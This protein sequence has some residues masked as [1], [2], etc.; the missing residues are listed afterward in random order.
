MSSRFGLQ[1]KSD[2][3]G[4]CSASNGALSGQERKAITPAINAPH[5]IVL[6]TT[7][8]VHPATPRRDALGPTID[9]P[10]DA[11]FVVLES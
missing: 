8:I 9:F 4:P 10:S 11:T 7:P 3:R 2:P 5:K 1:R 6:T